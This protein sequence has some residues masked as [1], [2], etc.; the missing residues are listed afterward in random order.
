MCEVST[1][2]RAALLSLVISFGEMLCSFEKIKEK[3]LKS[4]ELDQPLY[5]IE[6]ETVLVK[7]SAYSKFSAKEF[8]AGIRTPVC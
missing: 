3:Q 6:K 5:L 8:L 4:T 7:L 1:L 2:T